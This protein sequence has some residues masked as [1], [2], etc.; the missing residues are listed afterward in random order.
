MGLDGVPRRSCDPRVPA[1]GRGGWR[2]TVDTG[3]TGLTQLTQPQGGATPTAGGATPVAGR[4]TPTGGVTPTGG[5]TPDA[6]G[7][8]WAAMATLSPDHLG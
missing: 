5:G 7:S 1:A 3:T 6:T 4:A 8:S 2:V